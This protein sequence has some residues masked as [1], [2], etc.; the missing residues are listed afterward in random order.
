MQSADSM[1]RLLRKHISERVTLMSQPAKLRKLFLTL[2]RD[3]KGRFTFKH[4]RGALLR[5]GCAKEIIDSDGGKALR[6][7]FNAS[8]T[9]GRM[10]WKDFAGRLLNISNT[11]T[12]AIQDAFDPDGPLKGVSPREKKRLI[13]RA[14]NKESIRAVGGKGF[15]KIFQHTLQVRSFTQPMLLKLF[16]NVDGDGDGF[17]T[18]DELAMA[19]EQI[20]IH[21][22]C[23][24]DFRSFARLVANKQAGDNDSLAQIAITR[25]VNLAFSSPTVAKTEGKSF[26]MGGGSRTHMRDRAVPPQGLRVAINLVRERI[27]AIPGCD[28]RQGIQKFFRS[29]D[30][31]GDGEL[32]LNELHEAFEKRL[33]ISAA[34]LHPADS[35]GLFE[36]LDRDKSAS[37]NEDEFVKIFAFSADMSMSKN[38]T[39][40]RNYSGTKN[41]L[42]PKI[43]SSNFDD[44]ESNSI[45]AR[46]KLL[47][48]VRERVALLCQRQGLKNLWVYTIAQ[49]N[50]RGMLNRAGFK[51]GL[52]RLGCRG[53]GPGDSDMLFDF[54]K[55]AERA[56]GIDKSPNCVNFSAFSRVFS[57]DTFYTIEEK[58]KIMKVMQ[59]DDATMV[60]AL[61]QDRSKVLS[62]RVRQHLNAEIPKELSSVFSIGTKRLKQLMQEAAWDV[63]RSEAMGSTA[64]TNPDTLTKIFRK[65]D[66]NGAGTSL[67]LTDF[68]DAIRNPGS[69]SITNVTN[70]DIDNLFSELCTKA[71]GSS[72]KTKESRLS[73]CALVK[74]IV[75]NMVHYPGK[76]AITYLFTDKAGDRGSLSREEIIQKLSKRGKL[77]RSMLPT[78]GNYNA[79]E[80]AHQSVPWDID[81]PE[82]VKEATKNMLSNMGA[83]ISKVGKKLQ[84][85]TENFQARQKH[86][87]KC[88]KNEIFPKYFTNIG[89]GHFAMETTKDSIGIGADKAAMNFYREDGGV[90]Q[91]K[92]KAPTDDTGVKRKQKR[93]PTGIG[94]LKFPNKK[95][96]TCLSNSDATFGSTTR[97]FWQEFRVSPRRRRQNLNIK[98]SN[99]NGAPFAISAVMQR[100]ETATPAPT[101]VPQE[102]AHHKETSS[103]IPSYPNSEVPSA[104][105]NRIVR[106][107]R[108]EP[109]PLVNKR[110][111]SENEGTKCQPKSMMSFGIKKDSNVRKA[112]SLD[113]RHKNVKY[114][115]IMSTTSGIHMNA[116]KAA[117]SKLIEMGSRSNSRCSNSLYASHRNSRVNKNKRGYLGKSTKRAFV[118]ARARQNSG[119]PSFKGVFFRSG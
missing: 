14:K 99:S 100:P 68:R 26:Y 84:D 118:P 61:P 59:N 28:G 116:L 98:S 78:H 79:K 5:I 69:L 96:E 105:A 12:G 44:L 58:H 57:P 107:N 27:S 31:D 2:N 87:S 55:E 119:F 90:N 18:I 39:S 47:A 76:A 72:L 109:S 15:L 21:N 13:T 73:I 51:A 22:V 70:E 40:H 66:S 103:A 6:R 86:R 54:V 115:P 93:K 106:S 92:M 83:T 67:S 75:P 38:L 88:Q 117:R 108:S 29:I 56:E 23:F 25:L 42:Q 43:S 37:I 19:I 94:F 102:Q 97:N 74:E 53:F 24:S 81:K 71:S 16:R 104:P 41:I 52:R 64:T 63:A 114:Y 8:A 48:H 17:L 50:R 20:G 3:Q 30:I 111:A 33:K 77:P 10:H 101:P 35:R 9:H 45:K 60:G 36:L 32:E 1:D 7:I 82:V 80:P 89:K 62:P 65:F 85:S 95:P 34:D 112:T 91:G 11:N 110:L 4:L 113:F 46:D 49:G